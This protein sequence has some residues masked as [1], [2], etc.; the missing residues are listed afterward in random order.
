M[1]CIVYQI[2]KKTGIKYAYESFSYWDR[3][4][5]QPRS[6]RKYLGRVD[7]QTGEILRESKSRQ[8]AAE[9]SE[10]NRPDLS[11]LYNE[12]RRKDE[13]IS[14]LTHELEAASQKYERL[15]EA[16]RKMRLFIAQEFSDVS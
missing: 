8:A 10:K 16:V 2:N 6:K 4:K 9:A 14:G 1:S 7:P 5:Q 13:I 3:D 12:L 11:S 15:A